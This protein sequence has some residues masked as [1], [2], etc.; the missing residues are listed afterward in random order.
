MSTATVARAILN[1]VADATVAANSGDAIFFAHQLWHAAFGGVRHM[2]CLNFRAAL[3][4]DREEQLR[5]DWGGLAQGA[6]QARGRP[7]RL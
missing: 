3:P 7:S 6:G 2:W 1:A 4:S 5:M